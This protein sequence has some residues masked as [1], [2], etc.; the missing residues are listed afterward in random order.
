MKNNPIIM[1]SCI[2][3]SHVARWNQASEEVQLLGKKPDLA[4]EKEEK[5]PPEPEQVEETQEEV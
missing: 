3:L 2:P 5:T 1:S 4:E